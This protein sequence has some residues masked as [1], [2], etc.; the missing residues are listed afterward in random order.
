MTILE[1][2]SFHIPCVVTDAGGNPEIVLDGQTGFVTPNRDREAFVNGILKLLDSNELRI[3]VGN[4]GRNRYENYFTVDKM[5]SLY[6][7][8]YLKI[9]S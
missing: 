3:K 8:L 1:A 7:N 9:R 4:A 5:V 2:M 6:Q